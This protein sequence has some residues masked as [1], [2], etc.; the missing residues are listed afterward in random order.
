MNNKRG[1]VDAWQ[2]VAEIGDP[3]RYAVESA[4]RRGANADIPTGLDGLVADAFAFQ[5]VD[6][7]KIRE[8]L[9]EKR[10]P[11]RDDGFL[12]SF[13]DAAVYSLRVVGSFNEVWRDPNDEDPF[14]H[15]LRSLSAQGAGHP[16]APP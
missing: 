7:V 1:H 12:D 10:R 14:S 5:Y 3:R 9:G 6:V 16:P 8:K 15:A 2:V 11:V 4:F 13:E